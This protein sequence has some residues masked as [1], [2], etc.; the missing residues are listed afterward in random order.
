VAQLAPMQPDDLIGESLGHYEILDLVGEG[1]MARVYRAKQTRLDRVVAVKVLP[2]QFASDRDF[3]ERFQ[4]EARA[5]AQ[6]AHANIVTVHD[7]GSARGRLYIV[8]EYLNGGNLKQR[9]MAKPLDLN[10][11]LLVVRQMG[12][13]LQYAHEHQIIHRDVKPM[14]VLL[15]NQTPVDPHDSRLPPI[16]RTVLSDFGIAKVMQ[17]SL[18]L[19]RVGAGVGTPEYMSP[20]QCQGVPID[21]RADIY[22]LGC[23]LYEMLTGQTPFVADNYT[24]LAHAHVYEQ[25]PAPMTRNPRISPAVQAV[26]LRALA[27]NP[28]ERFQSAREMV[29][30]FQQAVAEQ[31]P[32]PSAPPVG[33]AWTSVR[34]PRCGSQ[35]QPIQTYCSSCG[36]ALA[37]T[38]RA[39][40]QY[41][42]GA[43]DQAHMVACPKCQTLNAPINRFCT[44]CGGSLSVRICASCGTSHPIGMNYCTRCGRPL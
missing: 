33:A 15:D 18:T 38:P 13:A 35:N 24:A 1:G 39:A 27:K 44:L 14:N 36:L 16:Q 32:L 10:E 2:P 34:C 26:V 17:A 20:E 3:V 11:V 31:A 23:L 29:N 25:P 5:M 42:V 4:Q 7:A 9:M 40:P 41:P 22:A 30:S 28:A 12:D 21:S 43:A 19:T 37:G 6:L 8:M